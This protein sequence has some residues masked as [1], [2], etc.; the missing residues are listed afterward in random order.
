VISFEIT[1]TET[2]PE[3]SVPRNFVPDCTLYDAAGLLATANRG[4]L[5]D[6]ES[7]TDG[8]LSIDFNITN[9]GNN[10]WFFDWFN[11]T[12][13]NPAILAVV[14]NSNQGGYLYLYDGT[15]DED[16]GL[17]AA[18]AGANEVTVWHKPTEVSFC[19]VGGGENE[20]EGCTL[21][22]WGATRGGQNANGSKGGEVVHG[23]SWVPTGYATDGTLDSVFTGAPIATD[24]LLTALHYKGGPT[25]D[26]KK[27]L[28]LKQAVAAL[29]SAAHPDVDYPMTET[30]IADAVN[31]ALASGD[32]VEILSLH[33]TLDA[34][35]NLGCPLN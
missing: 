14:V 4:I 25:L 2:E 8:A 29:L 15:V 11:P 12:H 22:Y 19:Y 20:N 21:G 5:Q 17:H 13:P 23:D 34:Y 18:G 26:D 9:P 32:Q 1:T 27:N 33:M 16:F 7:F 3:S 35:N 10:G 31:A 30:E 6:E 24:T 28:L